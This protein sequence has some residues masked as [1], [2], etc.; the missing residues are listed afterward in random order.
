[1][2]SM[3]LWN[4]IEKPWK[5]LLAS[6]LRTKHTAP[7]KKPSDRSNAARPGEVEKRRCTRARCFCTLGFQSENQEKRFF[8][9][10]PNS[11]FTVS[12]TI[13]EIVGEISRFLQFRNFADMPNLF[14]SVDFRRTFYGILLE[15]WE[16]QMIDGQRGVMID[17]SWCIFRI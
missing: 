7:E 13:S 4:P 1:M 9:S 2:R 5:A 14:K 15:L 8:C 12:R 10:S 17:G 16:S 3:H 11:K 6:V